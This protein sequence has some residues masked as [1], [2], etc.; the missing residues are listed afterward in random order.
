MPG[1]PPKP[2]MPVTFTMLLTLVSS[3]NAE[4]PRRCGA[5]SAAIVPA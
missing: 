3:S 1:K 5:S 2:D 4:T